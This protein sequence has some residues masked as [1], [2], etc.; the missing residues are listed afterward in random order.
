MYRY[1]HFLPHS[2]ICRCINPGTN[3]LDLGEEIAGTIRQR[4][5]CCHVVDDVLVRYVDMTPLSQAK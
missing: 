2:A 3:H 1:I 5:D 4:T